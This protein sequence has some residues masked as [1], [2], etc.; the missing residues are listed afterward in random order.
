MT[1]CFHDTLT[2]TSTQAALPVVAVNLTEVNWNIG[3][4]SAKV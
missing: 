1:S 4:S 3:Q 2:L